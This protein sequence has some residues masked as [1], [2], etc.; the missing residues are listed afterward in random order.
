ML[1]LKAGART[2]MHTLPGLFREDAPDLGVEAATE[3][4]ERDPVG[5]RDRVFEIDPEFWYLKNYHRFLKALQRAPGL[6][7]RVPISDW[8]RRNGGQTPALQ[9]ERVARQLFSVADLIVFSP[10]PPWSCQYY[11]MDKHPWPE[12]SYLISGL[13][14]SSVMFNTL[15]DWYIWHGAMR[16]LAQAGKV[17]YLPKRG[18]DWEGARLRVPTL[19]RFPEDSPYHVSRNAFLDLYLERVVSDRLGCRHVLVGTANSPW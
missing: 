1:K 9:M 15:S 16:T 2:T 7:L 14:G 17:A 13:R 4:F 6:K 5:F 12:F 8:A 3:M 18:F 10:A 19:R 11:Q